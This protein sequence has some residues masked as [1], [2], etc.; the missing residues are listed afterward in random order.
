REDD[1]TERDAAVP[2]CSCGPRRTT[3]SGDKNRETCGSTFPADRAFGTA[4]RRLFGICRKGPGE[5]GNLELAPDSSATSPFS[6]R[7]PVASG[8]RLRNTDGLLRA[9]QTV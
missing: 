2:T 7:Y 3:R 6:A 4:A 8:R 1:R 9:G 5:P